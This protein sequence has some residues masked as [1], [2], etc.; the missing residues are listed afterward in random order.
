MKMTEDLYDAVVVSDE[1]DP[2]FS[3]GVRAKIL[4]FT[5]SYADEDQPMVYP[6]L[7][8]GQQSVPLKGYR[9]KVHFADGD[10]NLGRYTANYPHVGVT[11][12]GTDGYYR[13]YN[14]KTG[15]TTT[16]NPNGC[17]VTW[18]AAGTFLVESSS[19]YGN[20]G[21]GAANSAGTKNDAGLTE[22][23]T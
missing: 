15:V 13:T 11:N 10:I 16:V 4:G 2:N 5:D 23:T 17:T 19:A 14:R 3:G 8:N 12:L 18:D 21:A 20:A 6:D 7:T 22:A 1:V 9:L